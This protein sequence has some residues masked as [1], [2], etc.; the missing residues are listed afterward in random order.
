[1]LKEGQVYSCLLL[2]D[3]HHTELKKDDDLCTEDENVGWSGLYS[4]LLADPP[5]TRAASGITITTSKFSGHC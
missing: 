3:C 1:M 4:P 2:N 5:I